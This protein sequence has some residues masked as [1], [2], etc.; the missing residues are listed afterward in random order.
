MRRREAIG[1]LL[2][3]LAALPAHAEEKESIYRSSPPLPRGRTF[4]A[5]PEI[6]W[7]AFPN[8]MRRVSQVRV[9]I[10][11][12]EL[13]ARFDES[14][15]V[16]AKQERPLPVGEHNA[17]AEVRFDD[18]WRAMIRWQFTI[19]PAPPSPPAPPSDAHEMLVQVNAVRRAAGLPPLTLDA[20]LCWAAARHSEWQR[21]NNIF[22]HTQTAG[23]PGFFGESAED[24]AVA[25]GFP[26]SVYEGVQLG[27][28]RPREA[29]NLLFYAPYHRLAF[30]QPGTCGFGGAING[31][32]ATV[33]CEATKKSEVVTWPA[34]GQKGVP[35]SWLGNEI[36]NPLRMH[37]VKRGT[38]VG[39]ILSF[40]YFS[41]EMDEVSVRSA[42]IWGP[43]GELIPLYLNTPGNDDQLTNSAFVIPQKPLKPA[44][45]YTA[46]VLARVARTG[47]ELHRQWSF[48]TAATLR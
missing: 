3:T 5:T 22:G 24:R 30:L 6:I 16:V 25:C 43:D 33:L 7:P 36:P 41:E 17:L 38:A 1:G 9:A 37:P 46:S 21:K 15:G 10:G 26:E 11:N 47:Q 48:T 34:A 44:T 28:T 14:R 23:T 32:F 8:G 40:S 35:L 31:T 13:R 4:S 20:R 19:A 45:T 2:A 12:Q 39:T 18:G 27:E 42:A 29:V